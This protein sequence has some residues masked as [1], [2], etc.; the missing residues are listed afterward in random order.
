MRRRDVRTH[1]SARRRGLEAAHTDASTQRTTLSKTDNNI[2]TPISVCCVYG[3][4]V[5][6]CRLGWADSHLARGMVAAERSGSLSA[7]LSSREWA[8]VGAPG[9]C[10]MHTRQCAA[11][12]RCVLQGSTSHH[13]CMACLTGKV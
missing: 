7:A 3:G 11:G 10:E 12:N 13:R 2:R 6:P 5:T 1:L 8:A 4:L 9:P